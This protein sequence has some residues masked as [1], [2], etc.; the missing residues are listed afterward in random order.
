MK[1]ICLIFVLIFSIGCQKKYSNQSVEWKAGDGKP[2]VIHEDFKNSVIR[3]NTKTE[4]LER[5]VQKIGD[6]EVE[7]SFVQVV[8]SRKNKP[9]F[10]KMSYS[11]HP[12]NYLLKDI[13]KMKLGED[14][15]LADVKDKLPEVASSKIVSPLKIIFSNTKSFPNL[16]YQFDAIPKDGSS[17]MRW[18]V[19]RGFKVLEKVQVSSFF[20]GQGL[21]YPNGPNWSQI[22]EVPLSDLIGDGTLT[23]SNITVTTQS[24]L[25]ALSPEQL[26]E[27][28]PEDPRFDQVQVFHFA[29]KVIQMFK[30]RLGVELPFKVEF[31]THN[32]APAKKTIMYYYNRKVNLGQGDEV[33]YKNILKDPTI[34]MHETVHCFVDALAGLPQGSLNEAFADFFTTSFLNHPHLGEVSYMQGPFTRTVENTLVASDKKNVVYGDSLIISGTLWEIR[35]SI[36]VEKTEAL[37]VKVLMRLGPSGIFDNFGPLIWTLAQSELNEADKIKVKKILEQRQFLTTEGGV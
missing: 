26:F 32:G 33:N 30:S 6:A 15:F 20:D 5:F 9:V 19:S 34:V 2:S 14:Q 24:N 37:A 35:K 36:G 4:V 11:D 17:V 16:F 27:F 1:A 23:S 10:V 31:S 28:K 3:I 7:D 25:V 13:K 18:K 21:A 29:Q 22:E 8:K 12:K